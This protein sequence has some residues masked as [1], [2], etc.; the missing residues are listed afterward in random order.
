MSVRLRLAGLD[1]SEAAE[2]IF[3]FDAY[4]GG[5]GNSSNSKG[6]EVDEGGMP[7]RA[8][9]IQH[10]CCLPALLRMEVMTVTLEVGHSLYLMSRSRSRTRDP[11]YVFC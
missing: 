1:E 6:P 5:L 3:G 9:R 4:G 2:T 7:G 11:S 8:Y 10:S